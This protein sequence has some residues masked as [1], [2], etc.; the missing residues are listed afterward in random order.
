MI[1]PKTILNVGYV[2][3]IIL[4]LYFFWKKYQN[5]IESIKN[6]KESISE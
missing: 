2:V 5:S 3:G 1:N 6:K 4:I